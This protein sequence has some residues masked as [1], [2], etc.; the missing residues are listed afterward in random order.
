MNLFH[1]ASGFIAIFLCLVLTI[2]LLRHWKV[3]EAEQSP[4]FSKLLTSFV[5]PVFIFSQVANLKVEYSYLFFGAVILISELITGVAS[6]STAKWV[7]R[8]D[9]PSTGAFILGSTFGSSSQI[10]NAFLKVVFDNN[11]AISAM[12]LVTG[13]FGI[14][15]PVNVVG[16]VVAKSFGDSENKNSLFNLVKSIF[17][18]PP[19]IALILGILWSRLDIPSDIFIVKILFEGLNIIST[20]MTFL[21][22]VIIGLSL[23]PIKMKGIWIVLILAAFFQLALQPFIT[24]GIFSLLNEQNEHHQATLFLSAMPATPLAVVFC[25]RYGANAQLASQIVI[26]TCILSLI[27]IPIVSLFI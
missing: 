2:L 7:L 14:G 9:R 11:A 17:M 23:K 1:G 4:I 24:Y 22:A 6:W 12:G 3:I 8:L 21:V 18:N 15:L 5:L 16:P 20:S 10:G 27:S 19:T 25:A 13:Q 26:F